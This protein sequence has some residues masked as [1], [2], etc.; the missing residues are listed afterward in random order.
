M[1]WIQS[2]E[3]KQWEIIE[4]KE[5]D[6]AE[7]L[8][9]GEPIGK[10]LYGF[11]CC[12]SELGVE[13]IRELPKDAQDE[14]FD[15]L[16]T[17]EGCG[18]SF[19]RLPIAANDFAKSWYSYN[20]CEGDYAMEHFSIERDR[21]YILPAVVE[22]MKRSPTLRF[23]A[24]PWSPPTWMKHPPVYNYGRLIQTPENLKAYALYF[25]KY[26]EAYRQEGVR[27]EQI[28]VQNEIHADQKFPSCLWSGEELADF[29]VNYLAPVI[30]KDAEIWFGTIN[31]PEQ[32]TKTRHRQFLSRAMQV[33]GFADAISGA[34]Y[35][36]AG[37]FGITQAAEDYPALNTINS[38]MECGDG[39]NTWE[40]AMY[41]YEMMHHY[42]K[43]GARACVYWN[44]ALP[45]DS[46]STWGWKQNSLV[47]V[48]DGSYVYN[49]EFYLIKHFSHFVHEGA[50]ML[51]TKGGLSSSATAFQNPDGSRV[52]VIMNPFDFEK[53]VMLEGKSYMLAPRSFNTLL[54]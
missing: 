4:Q 46:I 8:R 41:S 16:F 47:T 7:E 6:N 53:A 38:E 50:V 39:T 15:E 52:A 25:K 43:Y 33:E 36:W 14:I 40:Y 51:S 30:G 12:I 44:M 31:G 34:S 5:C 19:C 13:A 32:T 18:F 17:A 21:K 26:L 9:L 10:P 11:G 54:L 27:V 3:Q 37:K 22:A 23:F 48:K 28:H 45:A 20:E 35:Q 24:S 2:T 1:K 42:F 49:P 29:I